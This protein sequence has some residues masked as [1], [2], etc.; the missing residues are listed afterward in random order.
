MTLSGWA[1][2]DGALTPTGPRIDLEP[3]NDTLVVFPSST[4]HEA[5]AVQCSPDAFA[6]ARFALVGFIRRVGR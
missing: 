4:R 6:D 5:H 1:R 2:A 3:A